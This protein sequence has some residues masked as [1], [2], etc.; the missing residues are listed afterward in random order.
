MA[1]EEEREKEELQP[2]GLGLD[3]EDKSEYSLASRLSFEKNIERFKLVQ[4]SNIYDF[5]DIATLVATE[6]VMRSVDFEP[7]ALKKGGVGPADSTED[8][9]PMHDYDDTNDES[10]HIHW[11][12]PHNYKFAGVI[13]VHLE[14]FVDSAPAGAEYV[15]WGLEYKKQSVGDNF[16]FG[17]GTT[18]IIVN[19]TITL[20]TPANDKKIHMGGDLSLTTDGFE[21]GDL[22]LMRIFRD[23]NASE[24]GAVDD[25]GADVRVFNYHLEYESDKLGEEMEE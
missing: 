22:V 5:I 2:E 8:G 3:F 21:G 16:D 24:T 14:W 20:G 4:Q 6:P 9:F 15:T 11:E 25:F 18:T 1:E 7:D 13:H 10:V 12:I 19:D 23:A 17:A